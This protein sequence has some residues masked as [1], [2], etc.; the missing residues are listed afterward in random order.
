MKVCAEIRG[1]SVASPRNRL[2]GSVD[3]LLGSA[4]LSFGRPRIRLVG[5]LHTMIGSLEVIESTKL[6]LGVREIV[7][8]KL[9]HPQST[10]DCVNLA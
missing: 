1:S 9:N 7:L 5:V 8:W 10:G 6:S 4:E 2:S 3:H